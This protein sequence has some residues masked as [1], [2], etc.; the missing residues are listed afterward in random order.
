[1][2]YFHTERQTYGDLTTNYP[3]SPEDQEQSFR[4]Y[5]EDMLSQG[6]EVVS[7]AWYSTAFVHVI[8]RVVAK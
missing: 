6:Y 8:F 4:D 1:M 7:H 3:H 5:L 2:T